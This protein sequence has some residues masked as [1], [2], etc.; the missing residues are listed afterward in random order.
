[1]E[2]IVKLWA[3]LIHYK[4]HSNIFAIGFLLS[5]FT[6]YLSFLTFHLLILC[7][8]FNISSL[9][10]HPSFFIFHLTS[11]II[12]FPSF[13]FHIQSFTF[14]TSYFKFNPSLFILNICHMVCHTSCKMTGHL[15]SVFSDWQECW[16]LVAKSIKRYKKFQVTKDRRIC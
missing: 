2:Y 1:M 15:W 3:I 5:T 8:A 14:H 13:T 12:H 16:H 4:K 11:V 6:C 9:T 10:F 7:F